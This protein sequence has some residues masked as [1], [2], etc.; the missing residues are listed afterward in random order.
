MYSSCGGGFDT[1]AFHDALTRC[2]IVFICAG[3]NPMSYEDPSLLRYLRRLNALRVPLGGMSGGSAILARAGLME[4]R[5][6]TVHWQHIAPLLEMNGELQIERKLYV[7]DRDRFSCAGGVAALDMM[8]AII[9][10]DHGKALARSISDWFIYSNLRSSDTPQEAGLSEQYGTD[11]PALVTALSSMLSHMSD[12]LTPRQLAMLSGISL[13]QL[14]RVFSLHFGMP[15]M[16]VYR[17]LR[18]EKADELLQQ[19]RLPILEVAMIT[20]FPNPAHF[21]RVFAQRYA[22]TPS[23]RRKEGQ[24]LNVVKEAPPLH[25]P[26]QT[27]SRS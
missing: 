25:M 13:R 17:N 9:E 21:S 20:G 14:H 5:R 4:G 26:R 6:F 10:R 7:I 12:P 19:S 11:H 3:G 18:L 27:A 1:S 15:M 8:C 22:V 2:D 23:E 24:S 16:E